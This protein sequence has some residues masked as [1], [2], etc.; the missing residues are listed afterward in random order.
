[1]KKKGN[2]YKRPKRGG[3]QRSPPKDQEFVFGN[4]GASRKKRGEH[5]DPVSEGGGEN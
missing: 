5:F 2:P 4:P 3:G 1:L